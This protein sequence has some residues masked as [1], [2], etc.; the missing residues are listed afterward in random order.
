MP[1]LKSAIKRVKTSKRNHLRNVNA[2]S[3][4]KTIIKKI[5]DIVANKDLDT[6]SKLRNEAFSLIDSATVK[7]MLHKN[8]SARKKSKI[9]KW[10]KSIESKA[11]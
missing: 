3:E 9:A 7:G 6:A 5:K 4:I 8:N 2:K 1:R 11:S 10:L